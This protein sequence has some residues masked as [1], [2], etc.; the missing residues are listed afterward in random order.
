LINSDVE[1]RKEGHVKFDP[2]DVYTPT[3][4]FPPTQSILSERE[5]GMDPLTVC[6]YSNRVLCCTYKIISLREEREGRERE[7]ERE[8]NNIQL[9]ARTSR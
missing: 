5:Q 6:F 8:K 9:Q 7:R 1:W 3:R 4:R 2:K